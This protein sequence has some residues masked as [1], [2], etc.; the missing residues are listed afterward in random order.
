MAIEMRPTV[1]SQGTAEAPENMSQSS[2]CQAPSTR[3]QNQYQQQQQQQLPADCLPCK[4]VGC[5][6]FSGLGLYSFYQAQQL[7]RNLVARR[8]GLGLMG[9]VFI[10]AAVYRLTM[11]T[12]Q[13]LSS[14]SKK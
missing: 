3:L 11:P 4:V 8:L 6:G 12:N 1:I 2:Q 7:P 13:E 9:T 10:G 14:L 5:V